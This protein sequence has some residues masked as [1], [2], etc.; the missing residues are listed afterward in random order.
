VAVEGNALLESTMVT[1]TQQA[2]L[3]MTLNSGSKV[4]L[5]LL[6]YDGDEVLIEGV[7]VFAL[8]P[9]SSVATA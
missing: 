6:N 3:P 1:Y 7:D 5:K 2:P 4:V 8:E 9:G